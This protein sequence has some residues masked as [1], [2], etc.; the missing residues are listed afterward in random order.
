MV[1]LTLSQLQPLAHP[2]SFHLLTPL[3]TT[4]SNSLDTAT[5]KVQFD[6]DLPCE[7]HYLTDLPI[8]T[9][10]MADREQ[11]YDPYIPSGGQGGAAAPGGGQN[12]GN[13]RT[14][15]LQAVSASII[16]M[17]RKGSATSTRPEIGAQGAHF[18]E[19]STGI[20]IMFTAMKLKWNTSPY[21]G[22]WLPV[23]MYRQARSIC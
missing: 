5:A 11:P 16:E 22:R 10:A 3:S 8:T 7:I 14:A 2:L 6:C 19:S 23:Q 9:E 12:P 1:D 15:A 18:S 4:A 13:Q 21:D 17:C 20:V